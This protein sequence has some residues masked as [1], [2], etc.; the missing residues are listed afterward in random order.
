MSTLYPV[1]AAHAFDRM[2]A[3]RVVSVSSRLILINGMGSILGPLVGTSLMKRFEI[4]GVFYLMAV[5]A[6][7]LSAFAAIERIR[8]PAA[9]RATRAF[10]ILAPQAAPH[11]NGEDELPSAH[12]KGGA[13]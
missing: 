13:Y 5:A 3:G 12:S 10:E 4:D 2:E 9:A 8:S 7:A 1:S 6:A 11:A